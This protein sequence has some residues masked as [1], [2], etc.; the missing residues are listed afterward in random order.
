[1]KHPANEDWMDWLY[2]EASTEQR[3]VLD[4]HLRECR[5]CAGR[6]AAWRSTGLTLDQWKLASA[7]PAPRA[8]GAPLKWAAA[9]A[10]IL[11]L[12][13]G[14]GRWSG[15]GATEMRAMR[16][17]M[18]REFK[19]QLQAMR[20]EVES[21][22]LTEALAQN[23]LATQQLLE[24]YAQAQEEKRVADL[25][26]VAAAIQNVDARRRLDHASLRN[27]LETMAVETED[28]LVELA[29]YSG[30]QNVK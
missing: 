19:D 28:S 7:R 5:E 26:S 1:M 23:S 14:V 8:W 2:G 18:E 30:A 27:A 3:A 4:G 10:L 29:G 13:F 25:Q 20:I 24:S 12:G 21:Q 17:A 9:A 15:P 6:V 22:I 11:G 16:V